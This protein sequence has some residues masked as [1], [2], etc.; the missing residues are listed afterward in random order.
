MVHCLAVLGRRTRKGVLFPDA[1]RC[2][3]ERRVCFWLG[4]GT[5]LSCGVVTVS[6]SEERREPRGVVLFPHPSDRGEVEAGGPVA[7]RCGAPGEHR[8]DK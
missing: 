2:V 8:P 1:F 7:G 5:R 4:A 6:Q 3:G